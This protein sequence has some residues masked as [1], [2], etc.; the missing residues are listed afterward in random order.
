MNAN[1][2]NALNEYVEKMSWKLVDYTTNY[3]PF[4]RIDLSQEYLETLINNFGDVE[5]ARYVNGNCK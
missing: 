3:N 4:H 1:L 5:K 2:E